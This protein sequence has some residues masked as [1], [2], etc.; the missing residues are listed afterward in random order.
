MS[1]M[2]MSRFTIIHI[3]V[4]LT[5]RRLTIP[6]D[7]SRKHKFQLSWIISSSNWR[8]HSTSSVALSRAMNFNSIVER[9]MHV[10]LEYFQDTAAPPSMKT[11]PLMNFESFLFDIQFAHPNTL[12]VLLKIQCNAVQNH[13]YILNSMTTLVGDDFT[14]HQYEEEKKVTNAYII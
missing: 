12:V 11:Y 10:C 1:T 3:S 2:N 4:C 7:G 14:P 6:I 9:A 13:E 8:S 5:N